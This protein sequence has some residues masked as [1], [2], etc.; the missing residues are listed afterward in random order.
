MAWCKLATN[1]YLGQC[2][3][4]SPMCHCLINWQ[5]VYE[6]YECIKSWKGD[7][8]KCILY[9]THPWQCDITYCMIVMFYEFGDKIV[10]NVKF[11]SINMYFCRG[12]QNVWL[13][14]RNIWNLKIYGTLLFSVLILTVCLS[15]HGNKSIVHNTRLK[16]NKNKQKMIWTHKSLT[17]NS[18][19]LSFFCF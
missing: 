2:W 11:Y 16:I 19:F 15:N 18:C 5:W 12:K 9:M 7:I 8:T 1:Q 6:K 4:R 3:P 14:L 13:R 10:T 17:A